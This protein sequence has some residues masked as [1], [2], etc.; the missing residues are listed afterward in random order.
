MIDEY[1]RRIHPR[2]KNRYKLITHNDDINITE[3]ELQLIDDKIIH[4]FA[5]NVL[6]AHPKITPIP[7]GLENAYYANA[8]Y[9]PF[10]KKPLPSQKTRLPRILV[11]FNTTSNSEER[12]KALEALSHDIN[13]DI[14]KKRYSQPDY[15]LTVKRYCFVASPPGNGEECHRTWETMLLGVI[16]VVKRS[17]GIEYFKSLHLPLLIIDSWDELKNLSG[18]DLKSKYDLIM[19]K[20]NKKP[21]YM[22]YWRDLIL[23]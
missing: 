1:F 18:Y 7:I 11:G 15:V 17:V 10:Y 2:I 12:N 6:V 4:W 21:L 13:A 8:G 22:N 14:I 23:S 9:A 19:S 3:K 20:A 5:Q 16:P